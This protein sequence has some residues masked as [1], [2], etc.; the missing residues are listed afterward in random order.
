MVSEEEV[1]RVAENSRINLEDSEVEKFTEEFEAVLES[2]E[3][4]QEVDTEDVEPSF[5]PVDVGEQTREDEVEESVSQ[6]EA[7]ANT[8]NVENSKFKGPSV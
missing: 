2:F 1:G 8:D 6:D 5:H 4:L 7:F 3:S